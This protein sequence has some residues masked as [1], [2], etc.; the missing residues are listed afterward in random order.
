MALGGEVIGRLSGLEERRALIERVLAS[1]PFETA[2]RLRDLLRYLAER[3]E[4]EQPI[5]E[6]EIGVAVFGRPTGYD[7]SH[8]TLVRV[9]ISHLRKKL[10][11]Y[12]EEEGR[13]E[14]WE[15]FIPKGNYQLSFRP[16]NPQVRE[17]MRPIVS[18]PLP[19]VAVVPRAVR[20]AARW[21][22]PAAVAIALLIAGLLV[23]SWMLRSRKPPAAARPAV[24]QLWHDMFGNGQSTYVV[25]ADANLIEFEDAIGHQFTPGEYDNKNFERFAISR[26]PD[27]A[28]RR[29]V[30][31]A[32]SRPLTSIVDA[33]AAQRLALWAAAAGGQVELV[34]ARD[35]SLRQIAAQNTVLLGS[36]RADPWV[37]VFEERLNFQTVFEE[38]KPPSA[39]FANRRP[40][41]G[42]QAEYRVQWSERGYCRVAYLPNP[43]GSG[44]TLLLSGTDLYSSESGADFITREERVRDLRAR[45]GLKEGE[46]IPSFEVLLKTRLVSSAAPE[47]DVVAWRRY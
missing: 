35:M 47:F 34:G 8:D 44:A 2:A 16:L 19:E 30:L 45:F 26:I 7:T 15:I 1:H 25:L 14:S 38:G 18:L 37:N 23:Q 5:R 3:S 11:Q 40:Q 31:G 6:N 46:K 33:Q 29:L 21:K 43:K 42:E 27:A 10:Q 22:L 28:R 4:A 9:Q 41:P 12:F 17:T 39:W 13:K 24:A 20:R 36:R 32:L